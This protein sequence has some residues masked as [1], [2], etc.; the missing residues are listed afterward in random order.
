MEDPPIYEGPDRR[1]VTDPLTAALTNAVAHAAGPQ[2]RRTEPR[3]VTG[4]IQSGVVVALVLLV[5][6]SQF[7]LADRLNES[8]DEQE[9][10]RDAVS[11][12]LVESVRADPATD[13]AGAQKRATDTLIRCGFIEAPGNGR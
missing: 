4:I 1:A 8:D 6:V 7:R 2:P 12:F 13:P 10:F 9:E 3:D 5:L 11:C